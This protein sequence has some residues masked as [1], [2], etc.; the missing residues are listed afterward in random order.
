M[1]HA[2]EGEGDV[3]RFYQANTARFRRYGHGK[4]ALHRAVWAP[5]VESRDTAFHFVDDQI[6]TLLPSSPEIPKVIDL[7]CGLGST[8]NYL[9]SRRKIEGVGIT[10]SPMQAF[11]AAELAERSGNRGT[12]HFHE[13]DFHNVPP[14][15]AGFDLACSIE[16]FVH[17]S[18]PELFFRTA[19]NVLSPGGTLVICDDFLSDGVDA[20]VWQRY[21]KHIRR[22]KWGW[23][24]GTLL[25]VES[26]S[27]IARQAGFELVEATD[28]SQFLE[29]RRPRDRFIALL[30]KAAAITR[31]KGERARALI[32]GDALQRSLLSGVVG[33]HLVVFRRASG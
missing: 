19:A 21:E 31:V 1:K 27:A 14:D 5:G 32:G 29:L 6:L 4:Q 12:V 22:F 18:N 20:A 15:F 24:I 2:T 25:T 30:A 3:Q 23:H 10:I 26:V 9:A 8:L 28:L 17:S 7:G 16:A 33:Y 13:A 11:Y